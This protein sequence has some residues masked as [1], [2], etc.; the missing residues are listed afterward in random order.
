MYA[1][2]G[3]FSNTKRWRR[4]FLI[5][6]LKANSLTEAEVLALNKVLLYVYQ[7]MNIGCDMDRRPFFKAFVAKLMSIYKSFLIVTF[8]WRLHDGLLSMLW[9]NTLCTG[10][11]KSFSPCL[12]KVFS[13]S[14]RTPII[15]TKLWCFG[16]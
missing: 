9:L 1:V 13:S 7:H 3:F 14:M 10:T 15:M 5:E 4:L 12:L 6:F 16:W 8:S 2:G 11:W